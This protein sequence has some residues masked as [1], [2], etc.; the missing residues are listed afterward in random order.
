MRGDILRQGIL[1]LFLLI[2]FFGNPVVCQAGLELGIE[3][4]VYPAVEILHWPKGGDIW[5]GALEPG[6]TN[7]SYANT[8]KIRT[9]TSWGVEVAMEPERLEN[10]NGKFLSFPLQISGDEKETWI[11]L[12]LS[13]TVVLESLPLTGEKEEKI[14]FFFRQEICQDDPPGEYSAQI[15]FDI[16]LEY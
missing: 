13:P 9:N 10:E 5:Y 15:K 2:C 12:S 11:N 8:L 7:I 4:D 16:I 6:T 1:F 3:M 14:E